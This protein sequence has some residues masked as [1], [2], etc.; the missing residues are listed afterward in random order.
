[1]SKPLSIGAYYYPGWHRCPERDRPFPKNWSEWDLVFQAPARFAGH[2]QPNLPL[3]GRYDERDPAGFAARIDAA[4]DAGITHFIF[5]F[6]WS[7]GMQV[8]N[9]ALTEGFLACPA[10]SRLRFAVMWANRMPRRVLPV[11]DPQAAV[12][13]PS[14][15]V[16]TDP[17]DF[18]AL[19]EH[20]ADLAFARPTYVRWKDGLY[21]SI[22][23]TSFFL[24]QMGMESA[25]EAIAIA[26]RRLDQ[27]GLG[28]LHLAAIDPI[29]EFLP[30]L[31][32]IGF[33]SITHYMKLPDWKGPYTQDYRQLTEQRILEWETANAGSGL[34]YVPSVAPGWDATPRAVDYG[35]E[36]P[37][38]YPWSPIVTGRSPEAFA[39]F[40]RAG[41]GYAR[42]H[43]DDE[44]LLHIASWN[45]WSEGH[46]LEPDQ[47]YGRAW[48]EAVK[49]GS[50]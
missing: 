22:F 27:R 12:L 32:E 35:R 40:V 18:L 34:P 1:M 5:A 41:A 17:D 25:R 21:F 14:R 33:D 15:F 4:R 13:D 10:S 37:Q 9:R 45:E 8:L 38:R 42:C 29:P 43:H 11:K 19:I 47:R 7:R 36:K 16:H 24:R 26:R 30:H 20:L 31:R 2:E 46:Y 28:R 3:W 48:L 49:R 23:D 39:D 44:P 50:A 6:Y